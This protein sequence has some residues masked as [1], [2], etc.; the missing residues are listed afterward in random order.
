MSTGVSTDTV[1]CGGG[2]G[3]AWGGCAGCVDFAA[4]VYG[5]GANVPIVS[6]VVA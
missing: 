5:G 1:I 4:V 3:D 2:A 6:F